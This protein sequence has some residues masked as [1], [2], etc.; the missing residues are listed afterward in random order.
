MRKVFSVLL[1]LLVTVP[2]MAQSWGPLTLPQPTAADD[3]KV[4]SYS[5][6]L[7]QAI[8]SAASGGISGL[9]STR[10]PYATGATTLGDDAGL[11]YTAATDT[12]TVAGS[13]ATPSVAAAANADL[14]LF[15]SG[16]GGTLWGTVTTVGSLTACTSNGTTTIAKA[17]HGLTLL[18]GDT[19]RVTSATTAADVGF[20]RLVSSTAGTLVVSRALAG[21]DSDVALTVYRTGMALGPNGRLYNTSSLTGSTGTMFGT[22][23]SPQVNQ[24]GTAGYTALYVDATQTATG[25]GTK[26]LLDLA[27]DGTS[28]FSVSNAG[29]VTG[30]NSTWNKPNITTTLTSA[31]SLANA[32]PSTV[33]VPVQRSPAIRLEGHGWDTDGRDDKWEWWLDTLPTSG[34][35]TSSFLRFQYAKNSAAPTT[36]LTIDP[37]AGGASLSIRSINLSFGGTTSGSGPGIWSMLANPSA[38]N[39][40]N[41]ALVTYSMS[42]RTNTSGTQQFFALTPSYNQASGTASNTDLLI[43]RTETAVGSGAQYMIDAQVGGTSRF[44]VDNVGRVVARSYMVQLTAD[45]T[46]QFGNVVMPDAGTDGR[47]DI[48]TGSATSAIGVLAGI[49]ASAAGTAYNIAVDGIAYVTP[50][51]GTAVTRG[52]YLVMSATAG[53]VDD[54]ATLGAAGLTIGK[55]L[56]SE[57]MYTAASADVNLTNDTFKLSSAPG[58]AVG[59]PVIYYNG[60][61]ASAT[62]LTSGNTY[63]VQSITTDTITVAATKGGSKIDISGTG[64][65]AQYFLRLPQA[66]IGIQ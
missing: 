42:T 35:S 43:N 54:S 60:G 55:A 29:A 6:T 24:S 16:T 28:M 21:S 59:E 37:V 33:G 57:A 2:V 14:K 12:L 40:S 44:N 19:V 25:S 26:R 7:R 48:N 45:A 52:H 1:A 38:S 9:T 15:S 17:V 11:T 41:G 49:G 23:Y 3:G 47:F 13:V 58:W 34:S 30:V 27:A 20:Y 53:Y 56:Y 5:A 66:I 61:G 36:G 51:T 32:T 64:N 46:I 63:W 10:V 4:L 8:W 39:S 62:G 18:A 22:A 65:N 31:V 50:T